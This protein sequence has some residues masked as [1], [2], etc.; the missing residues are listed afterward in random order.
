MIH[1]DH[2]H[3]DLTTMYKHPMHQKISEIALYMNRSYEK[4]ITLE[5][6]S[7]QFY[8]SPSHLSRVFKRLTGFQFREYLQVVR[9]REAQKL[10]ETTSDPV[11]LIAESV[12]PLRYR[13]SNKK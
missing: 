8:I 4:P 5:Q 1:T 10:L 11:Q 6:V 12:T 13:K 9:I 2:E 7:K 3:I